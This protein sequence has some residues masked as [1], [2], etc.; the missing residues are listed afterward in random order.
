VLGD[1]DFSDDQ[2]VGERNMRMAQ[3]AKI[4]ISGKRG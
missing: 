2:I 4:E 3:A 1:P